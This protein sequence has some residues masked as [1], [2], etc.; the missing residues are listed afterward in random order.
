M[1]KK[2]DNDSTVDSGMSPIKSNT[3]A[4][5]TCFDIS[6][7]TWSNDLPPSNRSGLGMYMGPNPSL[8]TDSMSWFALDI[9]CCNFTVAVISVGKSSGPSSLLKDISTPSHMRLPITAIGL[10]GFPTVRCHSPTGAPVLRA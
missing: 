6:S 9:P 8:N 5:A 3:P 1:L 7:L 2:F 10:N 4:V